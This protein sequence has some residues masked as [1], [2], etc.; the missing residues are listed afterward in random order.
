MCLIC[1]RKQTRKLF[2]ARSTRKYF[3]FKFTNTKK[4]KGTTKIKPNRI[5]PNRNSLKTFFS[6]NL[7]IFEHSIISFPA[8]DDEFHWNIFAVFA[9]N[10]FSGWSG[11]GPGHMSY[12]L[13]TLIEWMHWPLH[14]F[15]PKI[16]CLLLFTALLSVFS[17]LHTVPR[18]V[19][20]LK[21]CSS[22]CCFFL[23]SILWLIYLQFAN[24]FMNTLM[25]CLSIGTYCK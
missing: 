8:L 18:P 10:S 17:L 14:D 20:H 7:N 19:A 2:H 16:Y 24:V 6:L 1:L 9:L 22:S 4:R 25:C 12:I 13:A 11:S 3:Q 5:K 15:W 21:C 23:L